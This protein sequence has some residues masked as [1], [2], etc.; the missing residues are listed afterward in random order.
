MSLKNVDCIIL[1]LIHLSSCMLSSSSRT[2]WPMHRS[3]L[4]KT[5]YSVHLANTSYLWNISYPTCCPSCPWN[6]F[7][8][9]VEWRH[10]LEPRRALVA[11]WE[12]SWL[13]DEEHT[14]VPGYVNHGTC[15]YVYLETHHRISHELWHD[16][17][18]SHN[19]HMICTRDV[20]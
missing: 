18:H 14:H 7:V 4:N 12:M 19:M 3:F 13:P 17:C 10:S 11:D 8:I 16:V 6:V 20:D 5:I 2:T 15:Y 9:P 1:K